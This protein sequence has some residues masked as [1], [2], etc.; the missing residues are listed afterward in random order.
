VRKRK[1]QEGFRQTTSK[2][3]AAIFNILKERVHNVVFLDLYAG[4]GTV[5]LEALRKGAKEAIFVENNPQRC[6]AIRKKAEKYRFLS[7]SKIYCMD[8]YR[9]ILKTKKIN[10]K[11]DIVFLDPPYQ[12]DEAMKV[13]HLFDERILKGDSLVIVEHFFKIPLPEKIG[14]LRLSKKYTYGD[15]ILSLYILN[16]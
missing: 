1:Q 3:C 7:R 8:V 15:T 4:E 14:V 9:F 11:F 16:L 10:M 2:V 12:S 13:L 6:E 5:G